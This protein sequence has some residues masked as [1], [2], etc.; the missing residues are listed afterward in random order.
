VFDVEIS[1]MDPA[2]LR[3]VLSPARREA[4]EQLTLRARERVRDE[5]T[6]PRSLLDYL[7]VIQ[8]VLER[9]SVPAAA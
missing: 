8:H 4:F 7:R 6:S 5:F 1:S 9:S 2:R 3:S